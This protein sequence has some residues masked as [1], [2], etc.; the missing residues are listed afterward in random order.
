[1]SLITSKESDLD[2]LKNRGDEIANKGNS[3][4]VEPYEK[5][6]YKRWDDM[7]KKCNDVEASLL[8]KLKEI[9]N[10][11]QQP[12]VK[13]RRVLAEEEVLGRID[14]CYIVIQKNS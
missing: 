9:Q 6:I 8:S 2:L 14:S 12:P 13:Q 4:I 1:M 10:A 11:E 7:E 5:K 3:S